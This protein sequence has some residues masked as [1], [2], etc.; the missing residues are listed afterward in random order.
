MPHM[1]KIVK[2]KLPEPIGISSTELGKRIGLSQSS[3]SRIR[4]GERMPSYATWMKICAELNIPLDLEI[5]AYS[6]GIDG[7]KLLLAKVAPL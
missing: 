1:P 2:P 6:R 3:V 7:I 4:H 5:D